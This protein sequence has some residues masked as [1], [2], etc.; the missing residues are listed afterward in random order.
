[1]T[2]ASFA[3][4]LQTL[5]DDMRDVRGLAASTRSQSL[6]RKAPRWDD[7]RLD[8]AGPLGWMFIIERGRSSADR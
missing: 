3:E 7:T 2:R 4:T 5:G 6:S 1:M 8:I